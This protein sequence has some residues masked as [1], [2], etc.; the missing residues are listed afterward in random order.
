MFIKPSKITGWVFAIF[1]M[2]VAFKPYYFFVE[3]K[4]YEQINDFINTYF[5]Y[6]FIFFLGVWLADLWRGSYEKFERNCLNYCLKGNW[7]NDEYKNVYVNR[8]RHVLIWTLSKM[9]ILLCI[10]MGLILWAYSASFASNLYSIVK[11]NYRIINT[12][13]FLIGIMIY[14]ML[15]NAPFLLCVFFYNKFMD[16]YLN[17]KL[18]I[19]IKNYNDAK[20]FLSD[21][22]KLNEARDELVKF[23][24][25]QDE[26]FNLGLVEYK[27][28]QSNTQIHKL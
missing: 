27:K 28:N 19:S 3:K 6:L 13:V 12:P 17:S 15:L 10:C 9:S 11:T 24:R 25:K 8:N 18:A 16:K 5:L 14:V 7:L 1:I 20:K 4:L 21:Q 23:N 2:L 26:I 22:N